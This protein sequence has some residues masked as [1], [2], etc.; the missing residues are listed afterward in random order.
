MGTGLCD[1]ANS[2]QGT[3]A[4]SLVVDWNHV[5]KAAMVASETPARY[6]RALRFKRPRA[7]GKEAEAT[8]EAAVEV[9]VASLFVVTAEV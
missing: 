7:I 9:V 5:R 4:H 6:L 1:Q 8:A 2:K 3:L